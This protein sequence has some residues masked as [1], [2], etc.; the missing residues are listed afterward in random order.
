MAYVVPR[1]KLTWKE[2]IYLPS[3][4]A[5]LA[6][7][8]KHLK[9]MLTGQDQGRSCS[10]PRK[11]GMRRL[12]EHYRG[13][14]TLVTDEHGRERC[15]ACQL[16]EFICPPR[17]IT[18]T[19]EEIPARDQVRQGRE[20]PEGIRDRHDPL[21]L[22][23]HVRGGLP[24]AGHL[25][26]Q[27]LRHHRHHARRDG[28]RQGRSSTSSAASSTA[29]STSGTRNE[30]ERDCI[31]F[32]RCLRSSSSSSR[33]M[34]LVF[35]VARRRQSQSGRQRAE[36]GRLLSRP[37]R[38]VRRARRLLHRRHPGPGLCRRG[39]GAVPLHHHAARPEGG[40]AAQ[41]Q[42]RR[43][44]PAAVCVTLAFVAQLWLVLQ[45]FPARQAAVPAARPPARTSTTC[46]TSA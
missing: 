43:A 22:L 26:A 31:A 33:I 13:A 42:P 30:V 5:G 10:I 36:P 44:V 8:F 7:T 32:R 45:Q 18:I 19:P 24:R 23:R 15:V 46:A 39:D 14:P 21:H 9:Q 12:P 37:G 29:W 3:I 1:P 2:K 27:G 16:C 28:P 25:P 41:D 6:I 34:M 40:G 17:A 4:V 35:G 38:A 20:A 11:S